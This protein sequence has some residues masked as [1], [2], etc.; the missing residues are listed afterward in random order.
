M[1]INACSF[2][3]AKFDDI[4]EDVTSW[5]AMRLVVEIIVF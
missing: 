5:V 4:Y 3:N 1:L 2:D